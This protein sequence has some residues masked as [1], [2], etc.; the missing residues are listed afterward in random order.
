VRTVKRARAILL[1]GLVACLGCDD[2][3]EFRGQYSGVIV[4]GNFVRSCF[5]SNT[6]ATLQ[7]DP[8][9]AISRDGWPTDESGRPVSPNTLSTSDRTFDATP[10]DPIGPLPHDPLSQLDFPGPDRLRNYILIARPKAGPLAG[11]DA[12]I[13]ISL[14]ASE[15]VEVRI[16]ARTVDG[17]EQCADDGASDAGTPDAGTPPDPSAP[18]EYFGLFRMKR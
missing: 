4:E 18:R 11:R 1:A 14:L 15:S 6:T 13:V 5:A 17:S 7:F 3:K 9:R 2:L 16:I 10:L 8:D 12:T